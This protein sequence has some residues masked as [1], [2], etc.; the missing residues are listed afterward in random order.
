MRGRNQRDGDNSQGINM[1][2]MVNGEAAPLGNQDAV[3][4]SPSQSHG[5]SASDERTFRQTEVNDIIKRA[6]H[7]AV[8]SYRRINA[9]QPQYAQQKYANNIQPHPQSQSF[10]EASFRKLAAEEAQRLRDDW[11]R[12]ARMQHETQEAERVVQKFNSLYQPGREKYQ[13][14]DSITSDIDLASFPNVVQILAEHVDNPQDILYEF[15]RDRIKMASMEQLAKMS[16]RDAIT[17]AKRLSQSLKDNESAASV[18][19]PKPPLDQLRPSNTGTGSTNGAMS[20]SEFR[21][22]Y[23]V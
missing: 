8:E 18:K 13:D 17:Q 22:K 16:H 2:D 6:K 3:A 23:R 7:D 11:V 20:V 14:F 10:D 5:E 12:D 15:G 19:L 21:R 4:A 1:T 9:E